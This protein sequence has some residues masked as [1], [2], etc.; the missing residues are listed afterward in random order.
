M[1]CRTAQWRLLVLIGCGTACGSTEPGQTG[2]GGLSPGPSVQ[3]ALY[4]DAWAKN[5]WADML[6]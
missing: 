3:E 1:S 4:A 5:I 2:S 6:T